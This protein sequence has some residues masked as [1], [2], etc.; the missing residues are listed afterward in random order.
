MNAVVVLLDRL[1]FPCREPYGAIHVHP[2]KLRRLGARSAIFD[3]HFCG[4]PSC[5]PARR[6]PLASRQECLRRGWAR[7][8]SAF[9]GARRC[10]VTLPIC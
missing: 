5:L 6:Q 8:L 4:S 1:N 7:Q 10:I 2:P 3:N 9:T